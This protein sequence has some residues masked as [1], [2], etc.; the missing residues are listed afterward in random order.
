MIPSWCATRSRTEAAAWR[1][2]LLSPGHYLRF[3]GEIAFA[4]RVPPQPV[5]HPKKKMNIGFF[6]SFQERKGKTL[7]FWKK[8]AKNFYS[9]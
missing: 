2:R 6:I 4:I 3:G 7:L 5:D 1:A 8:E 9:F